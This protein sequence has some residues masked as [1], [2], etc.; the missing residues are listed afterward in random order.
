[1]KNKYNI[2][3]ERD[4]IKSALKAPDGYFNTLEDNILKNTIGTS[5]KKKFNPWFLR[6]AGIAAS[7]IFFMGLYII[8]IKHDKPKIELG[9]VSV[10]EIL[11]QEDFELT[12]DD[13]INLVSLDDLNL[14]QEEIQESTANLDN[15]ELEDYDIYEEI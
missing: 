14:L 10:E 12:S 1:M 3:L 2:D 7:F 13:F 6:T 4:R 9:N 15:E 8:F 5:Q 11:D